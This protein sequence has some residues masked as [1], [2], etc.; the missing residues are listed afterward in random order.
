LILQEFQYKYSSDRNK[1]KRE[2]MRKILFTLCAS[3]IL[4]SAC[5]STDQG[6]IDRQDS[7][8]EAAA[9][10]SMLNSAM[11]ADSLIQDTITVDSIK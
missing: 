2:T 11:E 10:D 5:N 4:F 3:A 9:A 6:E 7:I 1:N 8:R